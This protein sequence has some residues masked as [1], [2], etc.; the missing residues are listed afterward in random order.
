[1]IYKALNDVLIYFL[2]QFMPLFNFQYI[3]KLI[4]KN[5]TFLILKLNRFLFLKFRKYIMS[6][7]LKFLIYKNYNISVYMRMY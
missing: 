4:K 7:I 6:F 1:M 2:H 3:L 5:F